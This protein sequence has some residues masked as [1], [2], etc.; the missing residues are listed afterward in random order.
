MER[1]RAGSDAAPGRPPRFPS[2]FV[3]RKRRSPPN[4]PHPQPR[5]APRRLVAIGL[6][7]AALIGGGPAAMSPMARAQAPAPPTQAN[8]GA[9]APDIEDIVRQAR[10]GV[11][12]DPRDGVR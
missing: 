4:R 6:I 8:L 3:P 2:G 1:L 9:L 5:S 10:E 7:V 11:A 12:Q